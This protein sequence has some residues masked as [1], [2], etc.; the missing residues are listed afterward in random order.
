MKHKLFFL[1]LSLSLFVCSCDLGTQVIEDTNKQVDIGT[2]SLADS[3][4]N[5]FF[6][7]GKSTLVFADTLGNKRYLFVSEE[8]LATNIPSQLLKLDS[9]T[10]KITT[11]NF[12][13]QVKRY[14]IKN[15]SFFVK[16]NLELRAQPY[17]ANPEGKYVADILSIFT[18]NQ[19]N[20]TVL[21]YLLE[22]SQRSWPTTFRP[23]A[24]DYLIL[25][26]PYTKVYTSTLLGKLS[27]IKFSY[28]QGIV[29][30]ID[31][32]GIEWRYLGS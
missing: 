10:T 13:T 1:L 12:T 7:K 25:G 21:T 32:A 16:F 26:K 9:F 6:Y 4:L 18:V 15:D 14:T 28:E 8:P 24:G 17:N 3:T 31:Q 5:G 23:P 20:S 19:V 11:Y 22:Y 30:Y 29:S 2:Y 27:T